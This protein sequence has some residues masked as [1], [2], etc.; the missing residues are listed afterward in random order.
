MPYI[1]K[2]EKKR[3]WIAEKKKKIWGRPEDQWIYKSA[4]WG[5][6]RS[7]QLQLE[8][9]CK[10]CRPKITEATIVDHITPVSQGGEIWDMDNLQSL[11]VSCHNR[12]SLLEQ[13]RNTKSKQS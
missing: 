2:K 11:C 3:P 12:K 10:G 6:V 8:P 1:P 5:R 7:L 4:R 9:F 13:N